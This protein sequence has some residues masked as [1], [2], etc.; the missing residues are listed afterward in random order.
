MPSLEEYVEEIKPIFESRWLTNMGAKHQLLTK[1]LKDYLAVDE[2]CLTVNGHMALELSLQALNLPKG[3]EIITTPF[4]FVSTTHAIVRSGFQPVFCD[5]D[6]MNCT[7]D[8]SKLESLITERTAAIL[9]VH[10][11]G[12][13]CDTEGIEEIAA[14]HGL[15]VLYDA[16]HTFGETVEV[17]GKTRGAGDFGDIS[18]FSFH[19]TKVF[20]T[21]EGGAICCH[22]A[23]MDEKLKIIRDFGIVDDEIISDVGPNAKMNE[24]AAA[25]GLCNL[26]HVDGEIEKRGRVADYYRERLGR[27]DGIRLNPVQVHVKSN[28]A[29]FPI[30][31]DEESY[32]ESRDQLH[33]RL[34][35]AGISARKYFYPMITELDCYRNRYN[36]DDTPVAKRLSH[37]VMTIPMYAD[38]TKEDADRVIKV[39]RRE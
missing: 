18:I 2:L 37:Q 5:V 31:V 16:A 27:V 19:A 14:K 33:L 36:S 25:M 9:P 39:I 6:P 22:S 11:Y 28:F 29:Y 10:V 3:A 17:N 24:F 21:I 8:V 1:E 20:H 23:E 38:L 13:I 35:E 7:M 15:K 34:Q 30:F 32:G 4:T 26:R 12:N